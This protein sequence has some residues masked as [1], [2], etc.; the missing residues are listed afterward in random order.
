MCC[1]RA[2]CA[3]PFICAQLFWDACAAPRSTGHS[4][5]A[6]PYDGALLNSDS[7]LFFHMVRCLR[8][9]IG[10]AGQATPAARPPPLPRKG[11]QGSSGQR[12]P[13]PLP[14]CSNSGQPGASSRFV[15]SNKGLPLQYQV[16]LESSVQ[17]GLILPK[18]P[19]STFEACNLE[20]VIPQN[21]TENDSNHFLAC[22]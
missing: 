5:I 22:N 14:F 4:I 13:A 16:R 2:G 21:T 10:W 1:T 11:R 12:Q 19:N 20:G 3:S 9:T 15:S 7:W 6:I 8:P 18:M 17:R